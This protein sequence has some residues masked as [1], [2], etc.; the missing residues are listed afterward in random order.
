MIKLS[1]MFCIGTFFRKT[2]EMRL[3]LVLGTLNPHE[4]RN[5]SC[6]VS[7]PF[8]FF[9]FFFS[10]I[11]ILLFRY[12]IYFASLYNHVFNYLQGIHSDE[13]L[14]S[15]MSV[16]RFFSLRCTTYQFIKLFLLISCFLFS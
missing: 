6:S 4:I 11:S 7:E 3:I 2:K 16:P 15:E 1:F 9:T 13:R 5:V 14:L 12:A 10:H 8:Y